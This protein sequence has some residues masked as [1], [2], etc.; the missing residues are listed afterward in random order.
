MA[1]AGCVMVVDDDAD[2][3]ESIGDILELR[4]YQVR[5]AANGREALD[6][7]REGPR[8]CV[9]LLDLM[10]PVMSGTEFY[11]EMRNDP[12]LAD[13]PVVVISADGNARRKVQAMGS[14]FIA[15][16]VKFDTVLDVVE[17]HCD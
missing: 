10:M 2:I 17:A 12:E 3:R 14:E 9:I 11:D 8:P 16:P 1:H 4:G 5:R 15:K 6:R 7:L 13:I